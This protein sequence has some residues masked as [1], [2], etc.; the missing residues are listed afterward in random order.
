MITKFRDVVK[1]KVKE[2]KEGIVSNFLFLSLGNR[3]I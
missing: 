3:F 1:F 2:R